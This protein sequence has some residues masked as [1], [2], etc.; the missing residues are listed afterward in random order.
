MLWHYICEAPSHTK[1]Y[2]YV[3]SSRVSVICANNN[4]IKIL[5]QNNSVPEGIE[6]FV[7][8]IFAERVIASCCGSAVCG[9]WIVVAKIIISV[10]S[11]RIIAHS[12]GLKW[13]RLVRWNILSARNGSLLQ[14]RGTLMLLMRNCRRM[15]KIRRVPLIKIS[16]TNL[17]CLSWPPMI[18]L[19]IPLLAEVLRQ[20]RFVH[21]QR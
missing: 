2:L 19:K 8:L 4:F 3:L 7:I 17:I 9:K 5:F 14:T 13:I 20:V 18:H 16:C 11:K 6:F 15:T 1:I 10:G 12:R 21:P